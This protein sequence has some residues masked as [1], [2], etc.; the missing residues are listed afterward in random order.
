MNAKFFQVPATKVRA[1]VLA[2]LSAEGT[3]L[4]D[5]Q[6][7][8]IALGDNAH[9][10]QMRAADKGNQLWG[11]D[12]AFDGKEVTVSLG[13]CDGAFYRILFERKSLPNG[14]VFYSPIL[15]EEPNA[16]VVNGRRVVGH[17]IVEHN[18]EGLVRLG[19]L[20]DRHYTGEPLVQLP[21][22]SLSNKKTPQPFATDR[23]RGYFEAN[24]KRLSGWI[25]VFE[26]QIKLA[27]LDQPARTLFYRGTM[28]VDTFKALSGDGRSLSALAKAGL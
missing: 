5:D 2:M 24:C 21:L 4:A 26:R 10:D 11:V 6:I 22:G 25:E 1:A 23:S 14:V 7:L 20:N 18:A 9:Y 3:T 12:L 16:P 19:D 13:R 27:E 15:I 28:G 8:E 17:V